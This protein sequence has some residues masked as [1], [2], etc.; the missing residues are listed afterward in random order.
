MRLPPRLTVHRDRYRRDDPLPDIED[1]D[2]RRDARFSLPRDRQREPERFGY[3]DLY[4]WSEDK[5]R[6]YA[7]PHR[8]GFR[9]YLARQGFA[10]D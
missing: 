3:A 8:T 2:R 7:S 1:Y 9:A 5:A 6:Q 4:G 10:L